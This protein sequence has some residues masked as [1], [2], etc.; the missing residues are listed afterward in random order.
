MRDLGLTWENRVVQKLDAVFAGHP[1]AVVQYH[2]LA[3]A[4]RAI[5]RMGFARAL[6]WVILGLRIYPSMI[7]VARRP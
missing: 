4:L 6:R 2:R 3:G 7:Y 5:E 1:D